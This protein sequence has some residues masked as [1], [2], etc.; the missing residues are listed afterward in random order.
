M[1]VLRSSP[2]PARE[3]AFRELVRRH[4][5]TVRAVAVSVTGDGAAAED[6]VQ[7][8]FLRVYQARERYVADRA[9]FRT[10]LARIAR[11][12]ALNARRDGAR[13]R[14]RSTALLDSD[15]APAAPDALPGEAL[16][17]DDRARALRAAIERL[18][19][20]EREVLALR[21]QQGLSYDEIGEAMGAGA[22]AIKQRAWRAMQRLRSIFDGSDA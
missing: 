14:A 21:Y 19:A 17:A 15:A 2:G 12:L 18:P 22:P 8:V 16:E 6:V 9:S 3:A 13:R 1:Q 7:E 4:A 5:A 11:N 10:W 20:A